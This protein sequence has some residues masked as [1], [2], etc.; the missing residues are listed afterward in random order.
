MAKLTDITVSLRINAIRAV[1]RKVSSV[2][3]RT[4]S[5]PTCGRAANAPYRRTVA[6]EVTEGCIDSH[7]TS[8][9]DAWHVRPSA[10][11]HRADTLASLMKLTGNG[12]A[13]YVGK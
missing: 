10:A 4:H 3:L 13:F 12:F 7:H 6:G 9:A 11:A 8:H 5:C 2:E 1:A